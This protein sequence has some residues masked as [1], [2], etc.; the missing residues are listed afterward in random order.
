MDRKEYLREDHKK[1]NHNEKR[2]EYIKKWKEEHKEQLKEYNKNYY[3]SKTKPR[4]VEARNGN[5]K[6]E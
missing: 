2:K 5:I 4:N 1:Y 6:A 3:E